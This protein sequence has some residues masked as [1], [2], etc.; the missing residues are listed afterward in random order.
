[1]IDHGEMMKALLREI[2]QMKDFFPGEPEHYYA[3]VQKKS[4]EGYTYFYTAAEY[5][6]F[7]EHR[8]RPLV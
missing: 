1:M 8:C 5:Q 2:G 7:A 6:K 4:G 3:R